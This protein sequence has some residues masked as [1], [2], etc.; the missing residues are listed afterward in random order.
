MKIVCQMKPYI[1]PFER[2]LALLELERLT[3]TT[4]RPLSGVNG[5]ELFEINTRIPAKKIATSLAYWER[6]FTSR[7]KQLSLQVLREATVNVIRNGTPLDE[8][9]KALPLPD[10]E[11]TVLPARRCLRYG[12]HG[13]HEYRGK[14][15]PQLV[16]ALINISRAG[17]GIIADPMCGS[18]TT[19]V[20]AMLAEG[21]A[22]GLDL[23]PLSVFMSRTKCSV[24]SLD[25]MDLR[26]AYEKMQ[27]TLLGKNPRRAKA[28]RLPYFESLPQPDREYLSQWFAKQVLHDLDLIATR[29]MKITLKPARDLMLLALSNILRSVSW[30]KDADL[31]VRKEVRVDDDADA[32]REF[33]DELDRTVRTVFAF[34]HQTN[35]APLGTFEIQEADARTATEIWHEYVGRVDVVITSPPYATALP[36]LD[37][38]RLSLSYLQLLSRPQQRKR[39]LCMIGNREVSRARRKA[40]WQSFQREKKV[41]PGTAVRLIEKIQTLNEGQQAGFRRQNLPALLARYFFDMRGVLTQIR[42]LLKPGAFAYV[43]VGNNHTIAGGQRVDIRTATMLAEISDSIGLTPVDQIPMEMLPSRDLFKRNAIPSESILV[44]EKTV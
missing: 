28:N 16:R 26:E 24:Q 8:I 44:L 42:L 30:Q 3:R 35:G 4:P 22:L 11:C 33:L 41:L 27:T 23:N 39:D 9:T 34:L 18:G 7:K 1:Q 32:I 10:D 17:G 6:I 38:D 40:F 5:Y 13:I 31:R 25:P 19:A 36:Y 15:F 37:T 43:V 12:T 21:H 20:E 29:I 2:R 14:F